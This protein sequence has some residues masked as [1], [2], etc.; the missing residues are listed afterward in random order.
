MR[1]RLSHLAGLLVLSTMFLF[2]ATN[3]AAQDNASPVITN[4]GFTGNFVTGTDGDHRFRGVEIQEPTN[5]IVDTPTMC[6]Q[7]VYG[8]GELAN[9][10]RFRGYPG[11]CNSTPGIESI[12]LFLGSCLDTQGRERLNRPCKGS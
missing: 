7:I 12:P 8:R 1:T 6:G 4:A 9:Q 5:V 11:P 10:S 3:V 2:G